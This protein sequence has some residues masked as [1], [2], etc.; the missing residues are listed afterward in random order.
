MYDKIYEG[1]PKDVGAFFEKVYDEAK[2]KYKYKLVGGHGLVVIGFGDDKVDGR[3]VSYWRL[4]NSHGVGWGV[5]G[6]GKFSVDIKD[7]WNR[8]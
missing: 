2:R 4:Q 6:V 5:N 7:P 8:P 1:G 3:K